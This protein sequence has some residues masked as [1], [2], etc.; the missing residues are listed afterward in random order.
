MHGLK[1]LGGTQAIL[2]IKP[3]VTNDLLA[4]YNS[5]SSKDDYRHAIN[6]VYYPYRETAVELL[7]ELNVMEPESPRVSSDS[8]EGRSRIRKALE[9]TTIDQLTTAANAAGDTKDT[10]FIPLLLSLSQQHSDINLQETIL[11]SIAEL[12]KEDQ[13]DAII[14]I[15]ERRAVDDGA[16]RY[17]FGIIGTQTTIQFLKERVLQDD[18]EKRTGALNLLRRLA[19]PTLKKYDE[20]EEEAI[21]FQIAAIQA[22]EEILNGSNEAARAAVIEELTRHGLLDASQN[23]PPFSLQNLLVKNRSDLTSE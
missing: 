7:K 9:S 5:Y 6:E 8:D 12:G 17:T 13:L 19:T 1:A 22:L 11:F 14:S 15:I 18:G 4:S 10:S 2:F 21:A 20:D 3:Y 16:A 23:T